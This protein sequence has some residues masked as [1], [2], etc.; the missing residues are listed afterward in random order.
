MGPAMKAEKAPQ[1][2]RI[3]NELAAGDRAAAERLFP[4]LYDEFRK[5]AHRYLAAERPGHTLDPTALVHEAYMKLVDQTQVVWLGKKHF[6]AAGAHIMR[7][8]LVD[9][10]RRKRRVKRGG[11]RHRI[12]LDEH[13]ALSP[14]R[15]EDVLAVDE[16]MV[17]LAEEDA[18]QAT[19][20]ELR[21]FGGLTVAE[22]AA[23]LGVPKRTVERKWTLARAW[24]RRELHEDRTR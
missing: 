12:T 3:V 8:I 6:F 15:H 4:L 24:L 22:V 18:R 10:A 13:V 5:L 9:H 21:F 2:T 23:V 14:E 11:G 20:V 7:H 17:K 16:A 1:I 19:I